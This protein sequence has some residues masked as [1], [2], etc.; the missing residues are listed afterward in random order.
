MSESQ[1]L[2]TLIKSSVIG[3]VPP[4]TKAGLSYERYQKLRSIG[5][6]TQLAYRVNLQTISAETLRYLGTLARGVHENKNVTEAANFL[7]WLQF[8]GV[9][10]L[11]ERY[12]MPGQDFRSLRGKVSELIL[13]CGERFRGGHQEANYSQSDIEAIN[14]KLDVL[15]SQA[16][17]PSPA[18]CAGVFE[19][20]LDD[21]LAGGRMPAVDVPRFKVEP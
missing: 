16:A 6:D 19:V 4:W 1:R 9:L 2:K 20:N 18:P 21:S 17:R 11:L 12:A 13:E 15:L 14:R 3:E 8:S 7:R 5:D 10:E